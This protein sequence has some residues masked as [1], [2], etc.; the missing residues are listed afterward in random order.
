MSKINIKQPQTICFEYRQEKSDPH[1]GSCLWADFVF[2]LE[3]Y[4]LSIMSDCDSYAYG[5]VPTP[6]HESMLQLMCR[7]NDDYLLGKI[8]DCTQLLEEESMVAAKAYAKELF[9]AWGSDA[10]LPYTLDDLMH[11]IENV[12][13]SDGSVLACSELADVLDSY[14]LE[15]VDSE[16]MYDCIKMDYPARAKKVCE[17]FRNHIQ[18]AIREYI[19]KDP[20]DEMITWP[21]ADA[22]A[23][24][25]LEHADCSRP[26]GGNHEL[27]ERECQNLGV[28]TTVDGAYRAGEDSMLDFLR[29]EIQSNGLEAWGEG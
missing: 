19:E 8:S 17:I 15:V 14:G 23:Q 22:A 7:I 27:Y 1:Y 2:D 3:K 25:L 26:E 18:P 10:V 24:A 21:Q 13:F 6:A 12:S 20:A 28:E 4:T 29:M 5:W 16:E 9:E 11:E